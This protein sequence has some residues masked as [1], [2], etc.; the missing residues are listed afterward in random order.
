MANEF[1]SRDDAYLYY[2]I[3]S[4]SKELSVSIASL[5]RFV[6]KLGFE[7]YSAFRKELSNEMLMN[8][9]LS[10]K[11]N[12]ILRKITTENDSIEQQLFKDINTMSKFIQNI[13]HQE[14]DKA[15]EAIAKSKSI[16]LMGLGISKSLIYFLDFRLKRMGIQT[17]LMVNGGV[18]FIEDLTTI[19][20]DDLIITIN[21]KREYREIVLASEFA[22]KNNIRMISLTEN[23]KGEIAKN[24]DIVLEVSRGPHTDLNC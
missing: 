23:P 21:F 9:D 11:C 14:V 4:M 8:L 7:N 2:S 22:C 3:E 17:K 12:R 18:E 13:N 10:L 16:I 1:L 5:S 19:S 24:A 20:K 15:I 6:K